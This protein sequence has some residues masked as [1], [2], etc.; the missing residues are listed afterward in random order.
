LEQQNHRR[1]LVKL[2]SLYT[3]ILEHSLQ[4]AAQI[5]LGFHSQPDA[6]LNMT[7]LQ[8]R[9]A[10]LPECPL[11]AGTSILQIYDRASG[12]LLNLGDPGSGK[13]TR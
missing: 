4:G 6:V 8:F 2:H 10:N 3:D 13:T 12:E 5:A 1:F 9:Q 7:R 11:P